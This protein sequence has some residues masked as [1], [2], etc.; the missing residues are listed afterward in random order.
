MVTLVLV[1]QLAAFAAGAVVTD[2]ASIDAS[3]RAA[4]FV[5]FF[6]RMFSFPETPNSQLR[7]G[8]LQNYNEFGYKNRE[9]DND[10]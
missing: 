1:A 6:M 9:F 5:A 10:L 4:N 3:A 8:L 7:R 2:R